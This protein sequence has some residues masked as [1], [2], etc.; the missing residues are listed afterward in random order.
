MSEAHFTMVFRGHA[1]DDGEIDV[2]DLA[3]ALL[4]LGDLFQSANSAINGDDSSAKVKVRATAQACFEVDLT[5]M[6]QAASA[7]TQILDFATGHQTE[8]AVAN[9]LADLVLKAGTMVAVPAGGLF[10]LLKWLKGRKP[11]RKEEREGDVILHI[12]DTTFTTNHY[13]ITLAENLA[14]RE[15]AKK[16][17]SVLERDGIE[18]ISAKQPGQEELRIERR[19]VSSFNV[20][21]TAEE[22]LADE[23]RQMNVQIVSLSFKDD[24]KWRLTDGGEPFSASIEDVDFLNKIAH[25]AVA[26]SKDDYLVCEV[27]ER[28]VRGPKGL[29]KER[30]IIKVLDHKKAP[31]Q[32][33]LL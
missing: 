14:V 31:R 1:V 8:I 24:N 3:P 13:V 30:A 16:L 23:T 12:G 26:F 2:Q 18:S 11:D 7:V 28:Q 4:A 17:V 19:D 9:Q 33:S 25:N 20:P 32:L 22:E 5:L 21:D 27:R 6:Q 29:R 10:A 15:S